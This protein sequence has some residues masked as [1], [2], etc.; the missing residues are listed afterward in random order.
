MPGKKLTDRLIYEL[1]DEQR[2]ALQELGEIAAKELI[3]A[4]E[5]TELTENVRK[6]H[7]ELGFKSSES[8]RSLF[9][10]PEIEI[11][12]SSRAR[13]KI[14]NVREQIKRALKKAIDAGLEDLEI[15]Q[16]QAKIYGISLTDGT[17][18]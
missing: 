6:S 7:Q 16:R 5:I 3:L 12:I 9:E 8:P 14:E 2:L 11:L 1:T 15:V 10:D 18:S 17:P 13:F 4:E